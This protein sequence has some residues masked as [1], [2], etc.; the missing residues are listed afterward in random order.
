MLSY[1]GFGISCTLAKWRDDQYVGDLDS[2][3][4]TATSWVC[5]QWWYKWTF[6]LHVTTLQIQQVAGP[7]FRR[8]WW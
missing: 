5:H 7:Q 3:V 4:L 6:W 8:G 1:L 2:T